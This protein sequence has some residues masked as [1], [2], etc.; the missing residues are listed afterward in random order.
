MTRE[1]AVI[2][3]IIGPERVD[4][5][6]LAGAVAELE[7]DVIVCHHLYLLTALVRAWFPERKILGVCHGFDLAEVHASIEISP[8]G[9]FSRLSLTAS[10]PN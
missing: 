10:C 2:R 7:P 3:D 1:E 9:V 5:R 8:F 4:I 6:P